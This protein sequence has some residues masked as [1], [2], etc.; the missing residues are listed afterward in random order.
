MKIVTFIFILIFSNN[1]FSETG[2]DHG[3][4]IT[5]CWKEELFS[6]QSNTTEYFLSVASRG[7]ARNTTVYY[8]KDYV[9]LSKIRM[10]DAKVV[11]LDNDGKC[12][13]IGYENFVNYLWY[14]PNG[15]YGTVLKIY[16]IF[17]GEYQDVSK[18]SNTK[19]Q[20]K[21]KKLYQEETQILLNIIEEEEYLTLLN[22]SEARFPW[23]GEALA[24]WASILA[25]NPNDYGIELF[26]QYYNETF[27]KQ[28]LIDLETKLFGQGYW[29]EEFYK[30]HPLLNLAIIAP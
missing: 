30:S 8:M 15:Y 29:G 10:I 25:M 12:E 18:F 27:T 5:F 11:D 1:L 22:P 19:T 24:I 14:L 17:S 7:S 4:N 2:Y 28:D 21:I 16:E 9:I 13:I 20:E 26:S 3:Q 6:T 23:R